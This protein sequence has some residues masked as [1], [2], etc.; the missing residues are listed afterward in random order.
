MGTYQRSL[1]YS[2]LD[3]GSMTLTGSETLMVNVLTYEKL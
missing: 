3:T 1:L 2:D